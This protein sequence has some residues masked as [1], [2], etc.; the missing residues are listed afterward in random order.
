MN[1]VG[2]DVS[3][4]K[5]TVAILRPMGG[6]VQTPKGVSHDMVSLE[7]LVYQILALGE[8]TRVVMEATGRYHE[9]VAQELH[10]HGIFVCVV[11]PLVIYGYC[12]GG[13]VRKVKNDQKDSLKIAKYALGH[14]VDLQEYTPMDAIRQQLKIFSRQYNLYMKSSVALQSNLV[15]LTDKVFP[16]ATNCF[17]AQSETTGTG[18]GW[19]SSPP[20]GTANASAASARRLLLNAI[21]SGASIGATT[22]LHRKLLISTLTVS[23]IYG[24]NS[25]FPTAR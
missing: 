18:N 11:N 6:V 3:K 15:F 19:I 8:D 12:A 22:I 14:W 21:K 25:F 23:D 7:H 24:F 13:K 17:P 9:P 1:A 4:G 16:G 5:S 10:S 20:F 2:I